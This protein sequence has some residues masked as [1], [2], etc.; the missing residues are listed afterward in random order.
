[1]TDIVSEPYPVPL[2]GQPPAGSLIY[3]PTVTGTVGFVGDT[4]TYTLALAAGQQLS[5][6]LT[7]GTG[8]IGTVT[9]EGPGGTTIG[10][11]TGSGPGATVV[12]QSAPIST[13]GTYS[14]I[15][16]G[17]GGT[18]GAY[19]MQA[20][21]NAVFKPS[22]AGNNTIAT[23]YNLDSAFESLGTTP[24][25]DRAGVVGTLG[26]TP[27]DF[28]AF[29]LTAG[30]YATIADKGTSGTASLALYDSSGNLMTEGT[31]GTGVDSIVEDLVAP[32]TGTYYAEVTGA[33]GLGYDLVALQGVRFHPPWHFVCQGPATQRRGCRPGCHR[34]GD[35]AALHSR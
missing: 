34:P 1:M 22:S 19:T 16:G 6:A 11:A 18:T 17:S 24:A 25:A 12:L 29:T 33:T 30:E 3:D 15:V 5:L 4:D 31:S 7:T 35:G 28:Y 26:A 2:T 23:A 13:A 14:L 9:L 21:L 20:I 8:L 32:F 10:S 27:S